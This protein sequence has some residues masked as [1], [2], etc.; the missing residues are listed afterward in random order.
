MTQWPEGVSFDGM[1]QDPSQLRAEHEQQWARAAA[2]ISIPALVVALVDNGTDGPEGLVLPLL[3]LPVA[4]LLVHAF[5]TRLP[6]PVLVVGTCAGPGLVFFLNYAE[7]A[8]FFPTL[9]A[10]LVTHQLKNQRLA[11]AI[12]LCLAALPFIAGVVVGV[13][14]GWAFWMLGIIL[15][16]SFGLL[17]RRNTDLLVAL[18]KSRAQ[19]AE[20]AVAGE[21]RRIAQDIHDLVGHSLS[22]VLLHVTGARRA[23]RRDPESA[24]AALAAAEEVGRESLAEI[25]RSVSLLRTDG[26]GETR[27]SPT[28]IDI[29]QLVEDNRRAGQTV[30]FETT[31]DLE[32]VDQRVGL[33]A[34]RVVQ[35]SL[36]NAAKHAT[37]APVSVEVSVTE[38]RCAVVVENDRMSPARP[39]LA[40]PGYGLIGMRERVQAA[41]GT[42]MVGPAGSVWRV[43][44]SLPFSDMAIPR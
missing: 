25:R 6:W 23:I 20:Q 13:D 18:E 30:V 43:E 37:G 24:E 17:G 8:M 3:L 7:G 14:A 27:P 4:T 38:G 21:R 12:A 16:F 35:E 36:A 29:S 39:A 10:V 41:G 33:T 11:M 9:A 26:S 22:V 42:L 5:V 1:N 28:A 40:E 15:G 32:S 31:G 2:G 34:Y 44:A 19:A